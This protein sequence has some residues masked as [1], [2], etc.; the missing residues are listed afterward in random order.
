MPTTFACPRATTSRA[1]PYC[2]LY[3]VAIL[4]LRASKP[5]N[6]FR[7]ERIIFRRT[8]SLQLFRMALILAFSFF[9]SSGEHFNIAVVVCAC[10]WWLSL[11][12]LLLFFCC[13]GWVFVGVVGCLLLSLC[14][15]LVDFALFFCHGCCYGCCC[16]G[17]SC[18][19][20]VVCCS[21]GV[22]GVDAASP[23]TLPCPLAS[24]PGP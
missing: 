18:S 17:C 12:W 4:P 15:V 6:H 9:C 19:L 2:S 22:G 24:C 11:L 10:W 5:G 20:L 8:D 21:A 7:S 16:G 3:I 23:K 13:C 1:P 14:L